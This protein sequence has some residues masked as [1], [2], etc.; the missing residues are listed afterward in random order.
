[1]A[2]RI[3]ASMT[4]PEAALQHFL[5]A[6]LPVDEVI[7]TNYDDLFELAA[8]REAVSVIPNAPRQGVQRWVLK[9]YG[10]VTHPDVVLTREDFLRY[11][12]RRVA[13]A[14]IVQAMLLTHHK[15]FVG[16]SLND[17]NFHKVADVVRRALDPDARKRP[18]FASVLKL[19]RKLF[20]EELWR[21]ELLFVPIGDELPAEESSESR[22]N[23]RRS[24]ATSSSHVSTALGGA[25][26][27]REQ[28]GTRRAETNGAQGLGGV[29]RCHRSSRGHG[30]TAQSVMCWGKVSATGSEERAPCGAARRQR[31][32]Q[33]ARRVRGR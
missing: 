8:G 15:L 11:E 2:D 26:K 6:S 9:M 23:S 16:F 30:A 10:C 13:L 3:A 17:E 21:D 32:A 24:K 20:V 31:R 7:T 14:G 29:F 33:R 27:E 28:S 18:C 4:R 19:E 5:L 22:R 25:G 1:M 12:Q